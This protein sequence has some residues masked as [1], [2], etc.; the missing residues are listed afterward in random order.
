MWLY[1]KIKL[2]KIRTINIQSV[3]TFTW[4]VMWLWAK[5]L[6]KKGYKGTK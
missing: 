3:W 5:R 4:L 6:S 1:H 2:I